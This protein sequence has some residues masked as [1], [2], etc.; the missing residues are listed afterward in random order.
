M[1]IFLLF[2]TYGIFLAHKI[3]L[4]IADLGRHLRNGKFLFQNPNLL[5][6]NFYSY[7]HSDFPVINHH[8]GSGIVFWNIFKIGGFPGLSLFNLFLSLATFFLFFWLAK[9]ASEAGL[10][11]LVS[12]FLIPLLAER[13]EIRPEVFS[14]FFA[15]VFFLFF[16]FPKISLVPPFTSD[17]LGQSSYLLFFRTAFGWY[18]SN[19]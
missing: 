9:K 6:H 13:T 4:V 8:W 15:G 12:L 16:I 14:Y 5:F 7:T 11:T 17:F 3:N 19:Q 1:V 18:F 10:A 2:F